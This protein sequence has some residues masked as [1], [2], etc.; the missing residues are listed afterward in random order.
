MWTTKEYIN[1]A[2]AKSGAPGRQN[3]LAKQIDRNSFE[4]SLVPV[5]CL[6]SPGKKNELS[7]KTADPIIKAKELLPL[8]VPA[9]VNPTTLKEISGESLEP[10]VPVSD[11]CG[12]PIW[13][14]DPAMFFSVPVYTQ[15]L[16]ISIFHQWVIG[17]FSIQMWFFSEV[18]AVKKYIAHPNANRMPHVFNEKDSYHNSYFLFLLFLIISVSL[19]ANYK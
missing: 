16:A 8:Q 12:L 5:L 2:H 15:Y 11:I 3:S 14:L 1:S 10:Q 9:A 19:P 18:A 4:T 17:F 7:Q 6:S 13:E